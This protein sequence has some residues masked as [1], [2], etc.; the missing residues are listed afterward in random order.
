MAYNRIDN[1]N[2]VCCD[3]VFEWPDYSQRFDLIV[4]IPPF[5][6]RIDNQFDFI[7][8]DI[9]TAE[10]FLIE[11]GINSIRMGGKLIAA[12]PTGIL[13]RGGSE[14]ELRKK[15]IGND[16]IDTIISFPSG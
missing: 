1:S 13:Y 12:L 2:Y 5:G 6:M 10:Q 16:L 4:S 9:K 11:K 3:S 14:L 7:N 8:P 15:L